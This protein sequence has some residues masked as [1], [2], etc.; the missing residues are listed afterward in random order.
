MPA[1][2]EGQS[3]DPSGP[4]PDRER[5][6]PPGA[7]GAPCDNGDDCVSGICE[8]QGCDPHQGVCADKERMCTMDLVPYC[9]CDN[10]TFESSS[11]CP[12][13]RFQT[14]G[15]CP[16]KLADG[17]GCTEPGQC[18]S[19]VCEGQGCG[20]DAAGTC[21]P[22]QRICTKD[23]RAYCGCDGSTFLASGTCAGRRYASK[24][25]CPSKK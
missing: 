24:G 10:R 7:P 20:A 4:P 11:G 22:A 14:R 17:A 15:E 2:D 5:P 16:G 18:A 3:R 23:R 21:V 9:D 1:P 19:G 25:D 13:R 12:G 6:P 8:G